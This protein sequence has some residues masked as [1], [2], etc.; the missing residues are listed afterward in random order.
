MLEIESALHNVEATTSSP[1][2]SAIADTMGAIEGVE[3]IGRSTFLAS[4]GQGK[5]VIKR[6]GDDRPPEHYLELLTGLVAGILALVSASAWNCE[7]R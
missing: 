2:L 1:P 7:R 6:M 3:R 4:A 5:L